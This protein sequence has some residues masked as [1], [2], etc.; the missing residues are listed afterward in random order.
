MFDIERFM[1]AVEVE[2]R[3]DNNGVIVIYQEPW[4]NFRRVNNWPQMEDPDFRKKIIA[5]CGKRS[6][7]VICA[8]FSAPDSY[9]DEWQFSAYKKPKKIDPGH[10]IVCNHHHIAHDGRCSN[11]TCSAEQVVRCNLW[12]KSPSRR[13][14]RARKGSWFGRLFHG[15]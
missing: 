10:C 11:I 4:S 2:S 8:R 1:R 5:L 3:Q 14:D 13:D 6:S 15:L 7:P 9:A 12:F